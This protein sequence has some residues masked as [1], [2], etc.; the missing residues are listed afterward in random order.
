MRRLKR[1]I[2]SFSLASTFLFSQT[3][4]ALSYFPHEAY[5]DLTSPFSTPA[6]WYFSGGTAATL[7]L[8]AT[9]DQTDVWAQRKAREVNGDFKFFRDT[10]AIAAA[11]FVYMF[12]M[13][14]AFL[15]THE[16]IYQ[17]LSVLMFK[18]TT[19]TFASTFL[20]KLATHE[21]RPDKRDQLSF[22]SGHSS[23][24]FAFASVVAEEHD[25][26]WGATAYSYAAITAFSRMHDNRHWLH[27]VVAGATIGASYGIGLATRENQKRNQTK[28]L[29]LPSD[30]LQG[31]AAMT[32][33]NF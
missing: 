8:I 17:D 1:S 2:A 28:V 27:D 24:S 32:T 33:I 18:A 9:H 30:D 31:V 13:E 12:G 29:I 25:W 15:F 5:Q 16:K 10:G 14:S 26:Y 20:L 21:T 22:P 3:S 6:V 7:I 11:N 23:L 19:Y 4:S